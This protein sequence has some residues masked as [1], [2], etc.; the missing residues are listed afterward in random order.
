MSHRLSSG[1][2]LIDR[3]QPIQFTFNGK[4]F[5]GFEGDTVAS[6]LLA[7][8]QT[9]VGRSFKYH[10]PRGILASGAEEPNALLGIGEGGRFE[11][12][13]RATTT[14]LHAG[15]V[16]TSQN[17]WPSLERDIGALNAWVADKLPVF[18]AGFYYKTF[19]FPRVAWKHLYEPIIRKAAGLG[20]APTEPDP[21]TYEHFHVHV[22][23]LVV[24]GGIAGLKAAREA[25]DAG[26]QV[27][28]VEQT[29]H[30]GGRS[31]VDGGKIDWMAAADWVTAQMADF[32]AMPNLTVRTR[33]MASG[34]YDHGY[35]M[36]YE[37][38]S[39]HRPGQPGAP[40]H[41][42][43]RVRAKDIVIA[44]GA[45]ERP[46]T[47][48]GND[49]PGVMLASAVRDYIGLW[50][51]MPGKRVVVCANNDDAYRTALAMADAGG[52]VEAVL[53]VRAEANGALPDAVRARGIQVRPGHGIVRA[54][55]G[56]KVDEVEIG[57]LSGDGISNRGEHMFCDLVAVSG[58]WSPV[59]H[60]WS[61]CGGKLT[62]QEDGAYFRPDPD[63][64]PLGADGGAMARAVGAA[65]GDLRLGEIM[66]D[67]PVEAHEEA[68]LE[69]HWFTPSMGKYAHGTKHFVDFQN[70]VT[71][72]DVRLAAREGYESVE[73]TKRYTTLGMATDQG[74]TSNI[75]GLALL[76]EELGAEIP[77][78]GT[79]T[80]RPPYTPIS[81]GAIAGSAKG[82]L[83]KA[84][85]QTPMHGW[86]DA[87]G[88]DWEPVGDWYR[89]FCYRR[90][91]EDRHAAVTREVLNARQNVGMLD[92]STLGKIVVKG[93]DAGN[94]LDLIYTNMMSNLKVGRCRYGL[95]CTENG[96][97]FDDGV[98]VRT[99]EDEFL[100]HT[101]SGGSDRV[102]A[103]MEEWLQTEWW[104]MKVW[105]A[106]V[107]DQWAQIAVAGPNARKVLEDAG[108]DVDLDKGSVKFMDYVEGTLAGVPARIFRISFSGEL[109][110]E[111]ATPAR[112]GLKLWEALAKAGEAHGIMPYGTEALHIMRAEKGF[113][114]IGD[115][116]DGTVIPQDLDLGWA[117]SKKKT[118][119][120][121]KRAQ[122]RTDLTRRGR[123]QLVGLMTED[124]A[125]V[126]PDGAHAVKRLREQVQMQTIGHVTSTYFSPT[127]G[128]SI[129]MGLVEDG[130]SRKGEWLDFPNGDE[131]IRAQ[132]VDPVFYDPKGEKQNV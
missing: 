46:L 103:H 90:S 113:I 81:M 127:L 47:F 88:A 29:A 35:A 92:A 106:N 80:F 101:T 38:V 126:L 64:P 87:N 60:L 117:V 68:P 55:G 12:N 109:S 124:P 33:A 79:T 54:K 21:D 130:L 107:T 31:M 118:D 15:M 95:M 53:D 75:N 41:R 49:M 61:H 57:K 14:E 111:I 34:L 25:A 50:G 78:V 7:N 4:S 119:F 123:K 116:T 108:T 70:D 110:Y 129:A 10:R 93:P 48:A 91:Y 115:E 114:M 45:I 128:H 5:D 3:E 112:H 105:A 71:A 32:A 59:V 76:A 2:L 17:H 36:V 40:R 26:K 102:H 20:Q 85:R 67:T 66:G 65:N 27:L 69:P 18:S 43:W 13:Q 73:H 22:D 39:D 83:F 44:T 77:E 37:R 122:Q 104:D 99:G 82:P 125:T 6:A 30:L 98:V 89:P 84:V 42:L 132:I 19:L 120:L 8:D 63:R 11:P 52:K 9:L 51:V 74:K 58:G 24:G 16:T 28:L 56:L 121:G 86:S 23:L 94:F 131:V 96:F 62:W 97:L 100:C 1:G 72:A